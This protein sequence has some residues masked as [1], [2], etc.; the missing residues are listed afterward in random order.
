MV[1][2][3]V[4]EK[5]SSENRKSMQVLPTPLSPMSSSLNSRSY[6]F[7]AIISP[8]DCCYT[9]CVFPS[10]PLS[11][12]RVKYNLCLRA[13]CHTLWDRRLACDAHNHNILRTGEWKK[14]GKRG[15]SARKCTVGI[16]ITFAECTAVPIGSSIPILWPVFFL[17]CRVCI[18]CYYARRAGRTITKP[19]LASLY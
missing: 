15:A 9:T 17:L 1:E 19:L 10:D 7:F 8:S 16:Y 11:H 6:V 2:M 3:K 13:H 18:M 4:V 5:A 12:S 14:I